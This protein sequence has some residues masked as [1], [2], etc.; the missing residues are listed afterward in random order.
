MKRSGRL[1]GWHIFFW[2]LRKQR[3]KKHGKG[4]RDWLTAI[5]VAS[6]AQW[7]VDHQHRKVYV[8]PLHGRV[9]QWLGNRFCA[10]LRNTCR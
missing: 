8:M 4:K 9:A 10:P 5:Y 2:A 7:I 1:Y 6:C 3:R